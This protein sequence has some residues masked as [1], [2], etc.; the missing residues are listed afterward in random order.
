MKS[1]ASPSDDPDPAPERPG[2]HT[3][4]G[5]AGPEIEL[6]LTEPPNASD[7]DTRRTLFKAAILLSVVVL[8]AVLYRVTP[9]RT[10]LEPA[11]ELAGWARRAGWWGVLAFYGA[12]AGLIFAGVPR[13][14]F[15]PVAG[16][17]YGFWGGLALCVGSASSSY[18]VTFLLVRGRPRS[19]ARVALPRRLAFLAR[20]PGFAGVALARLIPLPGMVITLALSLSS[21]RKT[22]YLLGTLV[23]LVPEAAPLVLLGCG[24]LHP[25][26]QSYV[27]YAVIAVL[28]GAS[29]WFALCY[30]RKRQ[31]EG[32]VS[33]EGR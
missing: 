9:L 15:C 22:S 14:L 7:S 13:L 29:F 24:L 20:N 17:L 18:F 16:A 25:G 27:H 11:G 26:P 23:G 30:Y 32:A 1:A 19:G 33:P 5:Q 6:V 3:G 31:N 4:S 21:V 10:W 12:S 28:L 2:P 8:G